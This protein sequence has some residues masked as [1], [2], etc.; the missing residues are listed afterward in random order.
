M[1]LGRNRLQVFTFIANDQF[2]RFALFIFLRQK[3]GENATHLKIDRSGP[4]FESRN[5]AILCRRSSE[6][7]K[8]VVPEAFR[9]AIVNRAESMGVGSLSLK[10]PSNVL[11]IHSD[12]FI[13]LSSVVRWE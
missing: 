11:S 2:R 6:R 12:F 9:P 3:S 8:Y 7:D 1:L 13:P 10:L 4:F 5:Q